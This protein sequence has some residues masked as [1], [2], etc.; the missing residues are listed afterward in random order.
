VRRRQGLD[1]PVAVARIDHQHLVGA[2]VAL[3]QELEQVDVAL[4]PAAD[5]HRHVARTPEIAEGQAHDP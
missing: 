3:L 5:G 1:A 4:H 2:A